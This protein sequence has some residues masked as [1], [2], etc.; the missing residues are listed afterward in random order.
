MVLD[1]S[2]IPHYYYKSRDEEMNGQAARKNAN[3][4]FRLWGQ[5]GIALMSCHHKSL[6]IRF[7][8][9]MCMLTRCNKVLCRSVS[10]FGTHWAYNNFLRQLMLFRLRLRAVVSNLR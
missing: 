6:I 4:V 2:R 5:L 7:L 1:G 3:L 9:L 10:V 8:G